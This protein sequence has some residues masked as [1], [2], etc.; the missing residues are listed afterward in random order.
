M[1][2]PVLGQFCAHCAEKIDPNVETEVM[3]LRTGTTKHGIFNQAPNYFEII[4]HEGC[5][6]D[7]MKLRVQRRGKYAPDSN[8]GY[9]T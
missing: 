2:V 9:S 4:V 8:K 7:Y 5:F 3:Q 6:N 1:S